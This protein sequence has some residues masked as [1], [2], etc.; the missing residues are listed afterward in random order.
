MSFGPHAPGVP[1]DPME[2]VL[3]LQT[4]SGGEAL[5]VASGTDGCEFTD[6]CQSNGCGFTDGC[7]TNGC[8]YT[9]FCN[10]NGC[11]GTNWCST[12]GCDA[13]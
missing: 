12:N 4:L 8:D 3:S 2:S 13:I 11:S 7:N 1:G 6:Y 5:D 9:D 10:T